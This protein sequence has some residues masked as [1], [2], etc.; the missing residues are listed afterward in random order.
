MS[1]LGTGLQCPGQ[2]AKLIESLCS[3]RT[4]TSQAL[5]LVVAYALGAKYC[6]SALLASDASDCFS[7]ACSSKMHICKG[8]VLCKEVL[9]GIGESA[10]GHVCCANST[11]ICRHRNRSVYMPV[12]PTA[13]GVIALRLG[14]PSFTMVCAHPML[15]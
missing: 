6:S 2:S 8:F 7:L 12:Y 11:E 13:E 3:I 1:M 4:V 14:V 15:C 9:A 10:H 5:V